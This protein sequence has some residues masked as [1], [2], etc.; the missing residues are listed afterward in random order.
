MLAYDLV[1]DRVA[2]IANYCVRG[3]NQGAITPDGSTIYM[4]HGSD[5]TDSHTSIL[6]ASN[7]KPTGTIT[8]G[9]DG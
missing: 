6:D 2:W 8:T 3:V 7:G 1:R 5:A 4:P 9:T